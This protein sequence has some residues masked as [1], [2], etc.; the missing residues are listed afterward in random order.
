M[1]HLV[2]RELQILFHD[3]QVPTH[4]SS[5]L[6]LYHISLTLP[7]LT[8]LHPIRQLAIP[9]LVRNAFT[10]ELWL[11]V[12]ATGNHISTPNLHDQFLLPHSSL[13]VNNTFSVSPLAPLFNNTISLLPYVLVTLTLLFL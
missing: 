11:P 8:L 4:S 6:P 10:S 7:P 2:Q 13:S 12:P 9:K 3:L 1:F 5:L